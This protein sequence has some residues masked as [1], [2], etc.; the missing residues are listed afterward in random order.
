MSKILVS[1]SS[2]EHLEDVLKK[3]IDGIILYID[4][5]SVN[6]SFYLNIDD[7]S[8]IDT[9]KEVF[10]CM[11]KLM[12]NNDLDELRRVMNILKNRKERILFYD[13]AVYKIACELGIENRLV[14]YQDHLNASVLSN[15]F[16]YDLGIRGSFITNDITGEELT[17]IKKNSKM[18]IF[19]LGYGYQPIFYSRRYLIKNYLKYIGEDVGREYNIISDN[20]V[21]Y[22]IKE[23]E[24]GTTIYS[25]RVINLVNYMDVLSDIDY[26]VL[27]EE[28]VDYNEFIRM[29]D[30]FI[31]R[32]KIQ[33]DT[34]LGF[35]KVKTIYKVK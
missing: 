35:F 11:N 24:F 2:R 3:D 34:Y 28:K 32:E 27:N 6:S 9:D 14:I 8:L 18:D 7:L 31:K 4:K 17:T 13:M 25:P 26:I 20:G 21:E 19:F 12:H 5:L 33:E 15:Q 29:V 30:K 16:Y 10:V 23:E 22:P 1:V